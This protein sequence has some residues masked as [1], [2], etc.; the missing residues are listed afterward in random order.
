LRPA[1]VADA[2]R[3]TPIADVSD[4]ILLYESVKSYAV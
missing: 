2:V 4:G 1:I 3:S